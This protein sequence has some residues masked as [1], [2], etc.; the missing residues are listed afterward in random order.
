[1]DI[2]QKDF[3]ILQGSSIR[4][5]GDVMDSDLD[6][7]GVYSTKA[8]IATLIADTTSISTRR[9]VNCGIGFCRLY[10]RWLIIV[11]II[12][13]IFFPTGSQRQDQEES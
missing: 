5:N 13:H 3:T 8:S 7:N 9:I 11:L 6:I 2:A 4:F 1:M 12:F 10:M